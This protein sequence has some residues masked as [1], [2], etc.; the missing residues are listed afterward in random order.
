MFVIIV[1][2]CLHLCFTR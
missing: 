2:F 1:S